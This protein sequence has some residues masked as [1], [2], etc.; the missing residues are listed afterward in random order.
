MKPSLSSRLMPRLLIVAGALLM[1]CTPADAPTAVRSGVRPQS[2]NADDQF[3]SV[4]DNDRVYGLDLQNGE[5]T[6]SDGVDVFLDP[7]LKQ[8]VAT[9]M[10]GI[11]STDWTASDLYQ[12][13]TSV[14]YNSGGN[15]G[16]TNTCQTLRAGGEDTA[17]AR[18]RP[19]VARKVR[20]KPFH[21]RVHRGGTRPGPDVVFDFAD[22]SLVVP[23]GSLLGAIPVH[24]PAGLPSRTQRALAP[25][26]L[27]LNLAP[28]APGVRHVTR[29][30]L[31]LGG[32]T[33]PCSDILNVSI[34]ST[35]RWAD[36][37]STPLAHFRDGIIN[38]G[39]NYVTADMASALQL[40]FEGF[41]LLNQQIM[42]GVLALEWNTNNCWQR[43]GT[44]QVMAGPVIELDQNEPWPP[45]TPFFM[46]NCHTESWQFSWDN[47]W[48]FPIDVQVCTID[49][50]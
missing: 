37:R 48:I 40:T 28:G 16:Q 34:P 41:D 47:V 38:A 11:N 17:T 15:C 33:D 10:Q 7:G 14:L 20:I 32:G 44:G 21:A 43:W 6:T 4:A 22:S 25:Q 45:L 23:T 9:M 39:V 1:S 30:Q 26:G 3:L 12:V 27:R 42:V 8:Q 19:P 2:G 29:A 46:L 49:Y 50:I 36:S 5:F 18:P 24:P 35:V 13:T 31:D